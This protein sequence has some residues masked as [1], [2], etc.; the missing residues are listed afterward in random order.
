[1]NKKIQNMHT[2]N[3]FQ[4]TQ[5]V[6][7]VQI[8]WFPTIE[9]ISFPILCFIFVPLYVSFSNPPYINYPQIPPLT[10]H[11]CVSSSMKSWFQ[12]NCFFSFSLFITISLTSNIW[13]PKW[14]SVQITKL[15]ESM[16]LPL[17]PT[18]TPSWWEC[19]WKNNLKIA[20]WVKNG[21]FDSQYFLS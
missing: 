5:M 15:K 3:N 11:P 9:N 16:I 1:M 18:P 7:H 10:Y 13:T 19:D 2:Q 4:T 21:W 6:N 20:L 12:G 14:V 8:N 17:P